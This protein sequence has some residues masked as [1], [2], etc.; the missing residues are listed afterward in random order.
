MEFRIFDDTI[1]FRKI[2]LSEWIKA[3]S[4]YSPQGSA[5]EPENWIKKECC[6]IE[7][8]KSCLKDSLLV[9]LCS[10]PLVGWICTYRSQD[11]QDAAGSRIDRKKQ[12]RV[13]KR[14]H[15]LVYTHRRKES[16]CLCKFFFI[17]MQD[18]LCTKARR[19]YSE[20]SVRDDSKSENSTPISQFLIHLY[21][22]PQCSLST[23]ANLISNI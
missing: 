10:G 12:W 16:K 4:R 20:E 7:R 17:K 19:I 13:S 21:R 8:H 18:N 2:V 11:T 23:V 6:I 15:L 5:V 1:T 9:L 14:W 22:L 3:K